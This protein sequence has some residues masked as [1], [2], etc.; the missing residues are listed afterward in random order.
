MFSIHILNTLQTILVHIL[1]IYH[2]KDP[3]SKAGLIILIL[4]VALAL[5]GFHSLYEGQLFRAHW[6]EYDVYLLPVEGDFLPDSD[7]FS[8]LRGVAGLAGVAGVGSSRNSG[9]LTS[10]SPV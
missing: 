2:F 8:S 9:F 5:H 7:D 6:G 1:S 3:D 10:I 4:K